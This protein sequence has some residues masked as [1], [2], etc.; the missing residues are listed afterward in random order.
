MKKNAFSL[1][2]LA[3]VLTIV[4]VVVGGSFKAVKIMREKSRT[5]EAREDIRAAKE[6]VTGYTYEFP[7]LPE[8]A[9]FDQNLTPVTGLKMKL[10]YHPDL[11]LTLEDICAVSSTN[12]RVVDNAR[13]P[14]RNIDDVAFVVVSGGSNANM[15]TAVDTTVTPNEVNIYSPSKEVDDNTTTGYINRASDEY[16]DIVGWMTL[17]QLQNEVECNETPLK[18]VNS[19]LPSTDVNNS[20][21]Y[22]ATIIVDGNYSTAIIICDTRCPS[23]PLPLHG[24]NNLTFDG[25][26]SISGLDIVTGIK[27]KTICPV[28]EVN[29]TVTE[30]TRQVKKRFAISVSL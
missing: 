29:C 12:L 28:V 10:L 25:V 13:S 30:G 27:N 5:A 24:D 2:E 21:D 9:E 11:N 15:Q 6:A 22:N 26:N 19:S 14:A 18:I 16:D 17:A 23:S 8:V 20:K 1:I 7:E 4:G 3:I